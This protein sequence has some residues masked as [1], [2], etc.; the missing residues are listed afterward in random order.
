M[1]SD[2]TSSE[3]QAFYVGYLPLPSPHK[4]FVAGLVSLLVVGMIGM[5]ALIASTQR[6]PGK[7]AVVSVEMGTWSGTVYN[8]PYPMMIHDDGSIHLLMGM[9]KFSVADT[10]AEF[11]GLRCEVDGWALDRSNRRAIQLDM[12]D[13]ALRA[14][15]GK[16]QPKPIESAASGSIELIGEI[17]DGKC[18]L[19]MMKP[20]DGKTHKACATLCIEGG[21]PPMFASAS[22]SESGQLPLVLVDGSTEL[23]SGVLEL[24]GEPV[25]I[26]GQLSMFGTLPILRMNTGSVQRWN[27]KSP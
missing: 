18:F 3:S 6:S 15:S 20:G 16:V 8:E 13:T 2:H 17:V 5:G 9:G 10:A 27:G 1:S 22:Q 19:G 25:Q 14:V 26:T 21:L 7:T 24:V 12:S 4:R 11:E 23:P